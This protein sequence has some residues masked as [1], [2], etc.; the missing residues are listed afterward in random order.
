MIYVAQ[1]KGFCGHVEEKWFATKEDATAFADRF[2]SYVEIIERQ[3]L[4]IRNPQA[5]LKTI[6]AE[7][8]THRRLVAE[9]TC[10]E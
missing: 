1:Y 8:E 5:R 4:T 9:R 10:H 3:G 7:H 6:G 2:P